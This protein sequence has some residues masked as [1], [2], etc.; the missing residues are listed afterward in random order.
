M[1][2][3]IN[4]GQNRI[5]ALKAEARAIYAELFGAGQQVLAYA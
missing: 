3:N 1:D 4:A 2:Q 5:S